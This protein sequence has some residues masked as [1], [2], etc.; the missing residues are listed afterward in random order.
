[1]AWL[2]LGVLSIILATWLK[3]L[4][5]FLKTVAEQKDKSNSKQVARVLVNKQELLYGKS[6]KETWGKVLIHLSFISAVLSV[7]KRSDIK[8]HLY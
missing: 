3:P 1:M 7:L 8:V 4:K 5:I 2:V 6:E